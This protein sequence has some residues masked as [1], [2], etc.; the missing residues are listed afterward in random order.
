MH[1]AVGMFDGVHIGHRAVLDAA[2][3]A[4][5]RTGGVAA[6]LTFS[7]HPSHLFRPQDPVRLIMADNA[8]VEALFQ[9]GMHA[10]IVQPFDPDFAAIEAEALIPHLRQAMPRLAAIYVGENWRFGRGRRGD[11]H[12]LVTE[13][14]KHGVHVVSAPRI[15]QDGEPISS[16]RIRAALTEGRMDDVNALLGSAYETIGVVTPGKQLGHTIGFPTLNLPWGATL[17]PRLGVYVQ[18]VFSADD[19]SGAAGYPAVANF[20]LRPTV[21]QT[22]AP[23]LE[24]H[25]IDEDCPFGPGDRLRVEWL[26][27]IR[28]EQ[29]FANVEGLRAAIAAD[30][31]TARARFGL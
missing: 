5:R 26:S 22:N 13:A 23:Q 15:N 2:V 21:E 8:K 12:M 14:K 10:V 3:L 6:V 7:P 29:K 25:I 16:T 9:L 24:V 30:R 19:K 20:G 1:L 11:I 31:S 28:P 4:A 27:F 18:R 17:P